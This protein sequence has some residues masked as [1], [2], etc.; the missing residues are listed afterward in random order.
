MEFLPLIVLLVGL[1]ATLL[2]VAMWLPGRRDRWEFL[3][4]S[5]AVQ[6]PPA[7]LRAI[8]LEL[9]RDCGIVDPDLATSAKPETAPRI[10]M[11]PNRTVFGTLPPQTIR[12]A[13]ELTAK[14][15]RAAETGSMP[16]RQTEVYYLG[17][18]MV[19]TVEGG[20]GVQSY[21]QE[22]LD[23]QRTRRPLSHESRSMEEAE[24]HL[25]DLGYRRI[26]PDSHP[27]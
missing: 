10:P 19:T 27:H 24:R 7:E 2:R 22:I 13:G 5:R 16:Q 17:P 11:G 8:M 20:H 26:P 25:H 15:A 18:S 21:P 3:A 12:E 4:S 23:A 9:D 6:H 1:A 14:L